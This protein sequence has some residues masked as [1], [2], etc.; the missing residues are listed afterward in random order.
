MITRRDLLIAA[1]A[2]GAAELLR[3]MTDAFATASQPTTPV[4]FK[5]PPGACDCHVHIF[6]DPQRFPFAATRTYTPE[7]ATVDELRNVHRALHLDRVVVIQA[8]V[9]GT[10]NSCTLDA[11]KQLGPRARGIAVIDEKTSSAE[12]DR[13]HRSGIRGVRINLGTAGQDDPAFA[14]E[15]LQKA[16]RQ[17]EG[18]PW[19]I[20]M[21]V[22][23]PVVAAI[24]KQL[25]AATV[26]IVFD[27]FGGAKAALGVQQAGM[28]SLLR[29][30][31][32]GKA[33]VK[34]SGAY[35]ASTAAPDYQD[36]T[37]LAKVFV[38][39]NPERVLWGTDW[40][41]PDTA[42][43]RE[44]SE[45]SPLLPIDDGRLLNLL[46]AWVPNIARRKVILVDNPAKLY[47][48]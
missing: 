8:S 37:A 17:V 30:L 9:Y 1:A 42:A 43:G 45:I 28:A 29:L 36:A 14:R 10:D 15:R 21:Y 11:I 13:M 38:A 24:E 2:A 20:Q 48:F 23:L 33:Y 16:L 3:P 47:G 44:P 34:I 39:A 22:G 26:P 19:H 32:N 40:P 41:H 35:R 31:Q 7:T 27:H 46:A 6:G 18:R 12:L 5:V 25:T 4:N